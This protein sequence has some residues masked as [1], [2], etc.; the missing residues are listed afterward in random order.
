MFRRRAVTSRFCERDLLR[1]ERVVQ[2]C[3]PD[4]RVEF[5][6][7]RTPS[8]VVSHNLP[9]QLTSF[10]GR[11][12][13]ISE[14]RRLFSDNRLVTLTGAGGVGK[15]RLAAQIAAQLAGEFGGGGWNTT[16]TVGSC[17][18]TGWQTDTTSLSPRTSSPCSRA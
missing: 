17:I 15:T 4:L 7:L 10:G 1:P 8:T 2:L 14:V 5:P 13:E 9:V 6:P 11:D 18:A 12:A 16:N 3:H